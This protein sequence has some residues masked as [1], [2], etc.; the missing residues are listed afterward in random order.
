MTGKK[1]CVVTGTRAEYGLLYPVLKEIKSRKNLQLQL[2][3][4][5]AHL[6]N[7]FGLTYRQIEKDGLFI[8]AKV[9]NL[10]SSDTKSAV[11]KSAGLA[12]ILIS[13]IF[14]RLNPDVVLLLGDRYESHAA[15]TTA[16]LMNIPLCHIHGGELTEGS[17][18]EQIRHSITKMS[19]LHFC[20]TEVYRNRIIQMGESPSRVFNTG[21]PGIDNII[22]LKL[23]SKGELE[24]NL[25]WNLSSQCALF[26][27]HPNIANENSLKEDLKDI[28]DIL[29]KSNIN[30]LFT[31]ANSD[32]GGSIINKAIETFCKIDINKYKVVKN[33]GQLRYLSAMKYAD[34]L[35]GNT[36]S[37][38]IEAANFSKP[39]V[40]IGDRQKGRL[41]GIN[42]IDCDIKKLRISIDIALSDNFINKCKNQKNI[43]GSGG[44]S[45][46]IV[47]I[48]SQYQGGVRKKFID[49]DSDNEN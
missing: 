19:Y 38:I 33:L 43:Y 5:T 37:G 14:S 3:V 4:T 18:D 22:N 12:T 15:A 41:K 6:S 7:E 11:S 40:N 32:H 8:D 42:V 26:T 36:S 21:S 30:I 9:E 35:I 49:Y 13:D 45:K 44:S 25:K 46:A 2:V 48:L 34:L 39:V 16:I 23:M 20:A 24:K 28:F 10:L 27:Y 17:I 31:Y 1:I 47:N 29:S